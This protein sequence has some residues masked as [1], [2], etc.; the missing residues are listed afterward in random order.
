MDTADE[1]QTAWMSA[2]AT[3]GSDKTHKAEPMRRISSRGSATGSRISKMPS[4]KSRSKLQTSVS[5][6]PSQA[7]GFEITG[8]AATFPDGLQGNNRAMDSSPY[9]IQHPHG[10][11]TSPEM[12]FPRIDGLHGPAL[13]E[14]VAPQHVDPS[15]INGTLDFETSMSGGSPT[16]T[17]DNL[18]EVT[19]PPREDGWILPMHSSP[20]TSVSSNSPPIQTLDSFTLGGPA[21]MSAENLETGMSTVVGDDQGSL[22]D[23]AAPA[24]EG[25]NARDHPL[26][27]S[28]FPHAD[29][30][31][32]CPWEGQTNCNHKPEKLKC[33]YE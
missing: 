20:I 17:W 18:S 4:S 2:A 27:R 1:F 3:A 5:Q 25:E 19:T 32:H 33:N 11:T 31:Y 10:L 13:N 15:A 8:N 28:A 23:W 26:Y 16:E 30:L 21:M 24:G 7:V 12:L 14:F 22:K 6:G 9:L 29:G